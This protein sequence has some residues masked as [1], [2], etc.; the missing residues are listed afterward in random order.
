MTP[1]TR[2][3]LLASAGAGAAGVGLGAGGYL[4]GVDSAEAGEALTGTIPFHGPHQ[5]GV[6]TPAQD[7][8]HFASFDLFTERRSELR[9]L[10]REWSRAAALMCAGRPLGE[11]AGDPPAPPADSGEAIGLSA[12]NLTVTFGFGPGLFENRGLRL[13]AR[14]PAVLKPIPP[15]PGDEL[16]G[17]ESGGDLCVQACADDP[18]VAFHAVRNLARIG[19]GTVAVR[20][21]ELGFGRTSSSTRRQETR[22][23]LIGFREGTNNLRGDDAEAM[24]TCVWVGSRD[25]AGWMRGGTYMVTRRIRMLLEA[26]DRSSLEEQER[27]I[28]RAKYSGAPLGGQEE[29]EQLDLAATSEG[30]PVIPND[31]HVRLAFSINPEERIL[32]RGYSFADGID[33]RTGELDAGT[34]FISFQRDPGRQFVA[35]QR[36]LGTSADALSSYLRHVGGAVFAIPPGARPGGYVGE[37][38]LS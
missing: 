14:R 21:S 17:S 28:G 12:A 36:R 25:H 5:A 2:R 30:R 11:G 26:W 9:E 38:L 33:E 34:F 18:R 22:R 37:G 24:R 29:S 19:R 15:L 27:T 35:I 10:M 23:N 31:A 1:I 4:A 6:T 16:E 7:R 13:R 32:R 3:R 20:W 8:L